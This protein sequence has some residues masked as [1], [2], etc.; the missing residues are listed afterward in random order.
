MIVT[1][2]ATLKG[3]QSKTFISALLCRELS[4]NKR[5]L[6]ISICSQNDINLYLGGKVEEY[7][8]YQSIESNDI[9]KSI[10]KTKFNNIDVIPYD[11][12][13]SL[14]IDNLLQTL[15]GGENRI[16]FLLN[17]VKDEYDYVILDSGP[18]LNI[19]TIAA[20]IASD[21]LISPALMCWSSI[22]GFIATSNALNEI[23]ELEL[24]K[25][26][27]L[28]LI[29]SRTKVLRDTETFE[30]ENYLEKQNWE[31]LGTLPFSS[32]LKS[33]LHNFEDYSKVKPNHMIEVNEL[34]KN[35]KSKII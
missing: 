13:N 33:A 3:G 29:R 6:A 16:K 26:I 10:I 35:I 27:H 28:G 12:N 9:R 4:I 20:L 22:N 31:E 18:N 32:A 30:V 11:I 2:I 24:T 14:N 5:V 1:T 19:S 8:L 17:Q 23:K 25:C 15:R 21:Y 34:L 7:Q